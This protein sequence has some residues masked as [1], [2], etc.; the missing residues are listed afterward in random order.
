[1]LSV[2]VL[3]ASYWQT[4]AE[5]VA[6]WQANS[7]YQ[8]A[9]IVIPTLL[10][11]LWHNRNQFKQHPAT[12][13]LLGIPAAALCAALWMAGDMVDIALLRQVALVLGVIAIVL[14][15]TGVRLFVALLPTLSVL[16]FLVPLGDLLLGPLKSALINFIEVFTT[17]TGFRSIFNQDDT[18]SSVSY[19]TLNSF[20]GNSTL[21][22]PN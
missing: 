3:L 10:Y 1:M 14:A 16:F 2:L 7:A 19:L 11:L 22:V 4:I 6:Q 18:L 17:L 8:F 13:S 12:G 15:A 9:W 21:N 5:T 20:Q